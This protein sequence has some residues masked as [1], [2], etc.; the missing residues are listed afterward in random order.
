[1]TSPSSPLKNEQ[2]SQA[3]K[4]SRLVRRLN[5]QIL[6]VEVQLLCSNP[7]IAG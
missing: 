2:L 6:N 1:M 5:C 3:M 7:F 4:I